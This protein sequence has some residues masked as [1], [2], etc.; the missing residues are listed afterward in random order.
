V[1]LLDRINQVCEM[2][3][4]DGV[5]L[6][7]Q[8]LSRRAGLQETTVGTMATRLKKDPGASVETGTLFKIA[9]GASVRAAWLFTGDGEVEG[10]VQTRLSMRVREAIY[11]SG[12]SQADV[13]RI[14]GLSSGYVSRVLSSERSDLRV[15]TVRILAAVLGV[16]F[17]WIATGLGHM[18]DD[19]E[20]VES[21][22]ADTQ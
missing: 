16:S 7:Y 21:V 4:V 5:P 8:D 11:R 19:I 15:S 13:E 14:A 2:R 3:G 9:A 6:T 1:T 22:R 12:L 17:R 10:K 20:T 18:D